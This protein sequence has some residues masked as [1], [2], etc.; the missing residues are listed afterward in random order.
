MPN[1]TYRLTATIQDGHTTFSGRTNAYDV[2]SGVNVATPFFGPQGSNGYCGYFC[3]KIENLP[4]GSTLESAKIGLYL[5]S[6][7]YTNGS[8]S[9]I[10]IAVENNLNTEPVA[11]ADRIIRGTIATVPWDRLGRS[12]AAVTR[13]GNRCGPTHSHPSGLS[14]Y[15]ASVRDPKALLVKAFCTDQGNASAPGRSLAVSQVHETENFAQCLQPLVNDPGWNSTEQ[16]VMVYI[17][18]DDTAAGSTTYG[19]GN[20]TGI[21]YENG[22]AASTATTN[23]QGRLNYFNAGNA[24]SRHPYISIDYVST[25]FTTNSRISKSTGAVA[26]TSRPKLIARWFGDR[27]LNEARRVAP[28]YAGAGDVPFQEMVTNFNPFSPAWGD[29][30]SNLGS[31]VKLHLTKR[32]LRPSGTPL[33][34]ND[35]SGQVSAV[36]WRTD[37][38]GGLGIKPSTYSFRFYFSP[39]TDPIAGLAPFVVSFKDDSTLKWGIQLSEYEL[40]TGTGFKMRLTSPTGGSSAWTTNSFSPRSSGSYY[41][42]EGQVSSDATNKVVVRVYDNDAKTPLATLTLNPS[43]VDFNRMVMCDEVSNQSGFLL[44]GMNMA[45]MELWDDYLLGMKFPT[46]AVSTGEGSPVIMEPWK[47]YEIGA[48][49]KPIELYQM[50]VATSV[51]SNGYVTLDR[52]A[53]LGHSRQT[54]VRSMGSVGYTKTT[55]SYGSGSSRTLDLY[56][57]NGTP[58]PGGWPVMVYAH[59]G[60]FIGGDKAFPGSEIG[61]VESIL[62]HGIALASINYTLGGIY[63]DALGQPYPAYNASSA[64]GWYQSFILNFKEAMNWVK[65]T[66]ASTYSLN[67]EKMVA[68]GHS[69]GGY[70]ALAAGVTAGVTD[71]GSGRNL[72]LAGG[73]SEYGTP[74]VADPKPKGIYVWAAPVNMQSLVSYDPTGSLEY[75]NFGVGRMYGTARIFCRLRA[76]FGSLTPTIL[77]TGVD[78]LITLN[79]SQRPPIAYCF[80]DSDYLVPSNNRVPQSANQALLL[81]DASNA[82]LA[83]TPADYSLDIV[84]FPYALHETVSMVDAQWGHFGNWLSAN[85]L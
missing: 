7:A 21:A 59:G 2:N 75:A 74:N 54:G 80:G 60:F 55:A 24:E 58:P 63:L 66:G 32:S 37:G 19:V 39:S 28:G 30:S 76:D 15:G 46:D 48:N 23:G 13:Y 47:V 18:S 82:S 73:V 81:E 79:P 56:V 61:F 38:F 26:K 83:G 4:Q 22:M 40:A 36:A 70:I 68:S 11:G 5:D 35:Y 84:E 16:W 12:A 44:F 62:S 53:K 85:I 52:S 67:G 17:F 33:Q 65:V 31:N 64:T 49:G 45:D 29:G 78:H 27:I 42:V 57:P 1:I 71:D 50:G 9:R 41:R 51:D 69:A 34:F 77:N 72:T 43:T 8:S 14:G 20:L 3:F 6:A 10:Y 25:D